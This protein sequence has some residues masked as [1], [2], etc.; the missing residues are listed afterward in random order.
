MGVPFDQQFEVELQR[1]KA[2]QLA[3]VLLTFLAPVIHGLLFQWLPYVLRARR[4]QQ[5]LRYAPFYRMLHHWNLLTRVRKITIFR[6]THY[7]QP[8]IVL[9]MFLYMGLQVFIATVKTKDLD[10]YPRYYTIGKRL[11]RL[12]SAVV[13]ALLV[14]IMRWDAVL[15]VSGLLP[16]KTLLFHKWLGRYM[17]LAV[18]LHSFATMKY[19]ID[20]KFYIMLYIPPQLFGFTALFALLMLN[21]LLFRFMRNWAF[22][23]FLDQHRV[24]NY[25]LC[26]FSGFHSKGNRKAIL[27]AVFAMWADRIVQRVVMY[28]HKRR[29][30]TRGKAR[31]EVLD[32]TTVRVSVPVGIADTNPNRWFRQFMPLV[33]TWRAGQHVYINVPGVK[34][35]QYH[36]M[37]IGSLALL[38]E[39]VLVIKVHRGF[40]RHLVKKLQKMQR[41]ASAPLSPSPSAIMLS[42]A[43]SY[44]SNSS[45]DS[46]DKLDQ[47]KSSI[48]AFARY[49]TFEPAMVH[50]MLAGFTG[51]Y[52]AHHQ[53]LLRFDSVVLFSAGLGASFTLPVALDLVQSIE[54]RDASG[55]YLG[56]PESCTVVLVVAMKRLENLQW[57]DHMW[58]LLMPYIR[59]GQIHLTVN[60]TQEVDTKEGEEQK[61]HQGADW[62]LFFHA[63]APLVG[64]GVRMLAGRPDFGAVIAEAA[65]LTTLDQLKSLACLGCGPE[66]FNG[67]IKEECQR[68]RTR[69]GPDIYCYVESF[70]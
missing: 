17:L 45:S 21:L 49:S 67:A 25:I 19:W 23:L 61:L 9:V 32:A 57:Y 56:R 28:M 13:P 58:P 41:N 59:S 39:I 47:Q 18:G 24:F 46:V 1:N 8:S 35:F 69:N 6:Q 4:T 66:A 20:L 50:E 10:N 51:P 44:V 16:E 52:G 7:Y 29:S 22:D 68:N 42:P 40:T 26:L 48:D 43:P 53:P 65:R 33:G 27:F 34:Y 3:A 55:D 37:T 11:G 54:A 2:I 70:G 38:G 31:F 60:L 62:Q 15:A 5:S 36:P 12:A 64:A 14:S 63:D 30:P